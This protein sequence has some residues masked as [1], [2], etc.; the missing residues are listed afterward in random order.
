MVRENGDLHAVVLAGPGHRLYPLIDESSPTPLPKALLPIAN[1][2]MLCWTIDWLISSGIRTLTVVVD[3]R[4]ASKVNHVLNKTYGEQC[5]VNIDMLIMVEHRGTTTI[6]RELADRLSAGCTNILMVPCDFCTNKEGLLST[7]ADRHRVNRAA[8]TAL[9]VPEPTLPAAMTNDDAENEAEERGDA[10]VIAID[11][12]GDETSELVFYSSKSDVEAD[13]VLGIYTSTMM[14]HPKLCL[15]MDLLDVHCYIV[16]TSLLKHSVFDK[17]GIYSFR[18]EALQR[19]VKQHS[20]TELIQPYILD[21]SDNNTYCLRAN[22]ICSYL[23]A[24]KTLAK[25][26]SG[27]RIPGTTDIPPKSQVGNDSMIGEHG[28]V[29]ERSTIKRSVVGNHVHIGASVKIANSVVLD[30]CVIEDGVKLDGCVIGPK[31]VI[32]ERTNLKSCEVAGQYTIEPGLVAKGEV[33][34]A[35]RELQNMFD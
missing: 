6:L 14:K 21:A 19:I 11:E 20:K 8:L 16:S 35:S 15:R 27:A 12:K 23:L 1:R 33:L 18:E 13:G 4:S 2:P 17:P 25:Y 28:R 24:N 26:F 32:R 30:G 34:G 22:S 5:L 7:M 3:S 9:F 29:G 10:V 31:A